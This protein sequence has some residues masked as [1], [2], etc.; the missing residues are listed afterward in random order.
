M[1]SLA[2]KVQLMASPKFKQNRTLP[3][4]EKG[5]ALSQEEGGSREWGWELEQQ[6]ED[7]RQ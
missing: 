3:R 6:W 2:V 7:G 4:Q 1:C 5:A